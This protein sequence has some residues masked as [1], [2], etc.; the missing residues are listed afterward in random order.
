MRAESI[1]GRGDIIESGD[2]QIRKQQR[3]EAFDG[4]LEALKHKTPNQAKHV[5]KR[6]TI[7]WP[8]RQEIR[9]P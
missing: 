4:G 7:F 1:P 5:R 8:F 3:E 6:G 9:P 2:L